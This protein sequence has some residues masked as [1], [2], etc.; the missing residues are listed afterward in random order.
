MEFWE[1]AVEVVRL[2]EC[3]DPVTGGFPWEAKTEFVEVVLLC[4]VLGL[5]VDGNV[6]VADGSLLWYDSLL[7]CPSGDFTFP[8]CFIGE[9]DI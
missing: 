1:D 7:F 6:S 4:G 5:E 3:V 2:C 9:R 8:C